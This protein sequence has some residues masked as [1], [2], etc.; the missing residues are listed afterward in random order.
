MTP[1][2]LQLIRDDDVILAAS[3]TPLAV[4][5]KERTDAISEMFDNVD[6]C[7]IYPTGKFF[8]R[9]DKCVSSLI[10]SV[11]AAA[12]EEHRQK[13][14]ETNIVSL[15]K[16]MEIDAEEYGTLHNEDCGVSA[17]ESYP[18]E[19]DCENIK[20]MKSFGKEWMGR[21]NEWWVLHATE[22][23]KYC[24]PEGNKMLTRMM[25]KKNRHLRSPT[26]SGYEFSL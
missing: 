9:L 24:S 10:D 7:G 6:E 23:R 13:F 22:H 14:L 16:E 12:L 1:D 11:H 17:D 2:K 5:Q 18:D 15:V 25:G 26:L 3:G 21:V 20:M 8:A 4:F 19:C